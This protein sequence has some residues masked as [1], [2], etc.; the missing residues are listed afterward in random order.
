MSAG[1]GCKRTQTNLVG[2]G[3]EGVGRGGF[4]QEIASERWLS[5]L[6]ELSA[7]PSGKCQI[8]GTRVRG[9]LARGVASRPARWKTRARSFAAWASPTWAVTSLSRCKR[10]R[11]TGRMHMGRSIFLHWHVLLA[12]RACDGAVLCVGRRFR[13]ETVRLKLRS[14]SFSICRRQRTS[15]I[16]RSSRLPIL[17]LLGLMV[18][19]VGRGA[20][21]VGNQ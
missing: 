13:T 21:V 15:Q 19:V 14:M 8:A 1:I 9:E 7:A 18:M 20:L 6:S 10:A 4:P 12:G 11:L 2:Q 16:P 5:P 17:M 3:R